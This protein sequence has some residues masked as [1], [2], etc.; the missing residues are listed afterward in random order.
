MV[1]GHDLLAEWHDDAGT[2]AVAGT[3]V[4]T[5]RETPQETA[6]RLVT[7]LGP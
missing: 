1:D 4:V 5:G 2:R 7:L 6:A 3:V